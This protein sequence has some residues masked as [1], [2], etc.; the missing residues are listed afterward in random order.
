[1]F[2]FNS[3]KEAHV[4]ITNRCQAACPMCA[5]NIHG[6]IENPELKVNDWTYEDF[7][8]IFPLELVKQLT[9]FVFCGSFGD[10][11]LNKDLDKM[12]LYVKEHNPDAS[13]S[14][15][16]NGSLRKSEWWAQLINS[17][18]RR[19]Q[20]VFALDGLEDT[21]SLY[22]IN[23][24]FN[25]IINNA[26]AFID[27]GG[28][29]TWHFIRFKHNEHQLDQ[30]K[31]LANELGFSDFITKNTRRF[32]NSNFKVVDDTGNVTHLLEPTTDNVIQFVDRK[33]LEKTYPAWSVSTD[34]NCMALNDAS[35]YIDAHFTA[36]P[37]CIIASWL[38][39]S[40]D[41][42]LLE[43]NGLYDESTTVNIMGAKVKKQVFE[44][45]EELGGFDAIDARTHG[46]Q[47]IIDSSIWQRIWHD[48]WE[49]SGSLTC[50]L[51][52]SSSSP[53]ISLQQQIIND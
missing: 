38:Y 12:C 32:T 4:E 21:H 6:G 53:F 43:K 52:C 11:I 18:P 2:N 45:V 41:T 44:I 7:V 50:G 39:T 40:Y 25:K 34:I 22:R 47:S 1:M 13:I 33:Y 31:A 36:M 35:I 5:R 23:T 24:N 8:H 30:C 10:P 42:I 20:V 3:L 19:H 51:M 49:N 27:A 16:T 9:S 37:C 29:A 46:I 26:K 28:N 14:I 48:K 15:H 17:L